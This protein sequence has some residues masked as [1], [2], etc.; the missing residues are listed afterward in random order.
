MSTEPNRSLS[1]VAPF[2]LFSAKD[3]ELFQAG[4]HERLYE[5]FG[6]H[7][8]EYEGVKGTYFAVWAPNAAY[9]SVM[10]DFNN[11]DRYTHTLLPRWDHSGI[12]EG[13]I[14]HVKKGTLYKYF[15]RAR[16]GEELFKGDPFALYWEQRPKTASITWELDYHWKDKKWMEKRQRHNSL[17][18][19]FSVYEVHLGSWR[20]PDPHNHEVF[21][22]YRE[23]AG[24]LAPYAK[25]MGF[26]HVELMPVGEHPFDGSW[27]YQQTGYYAPTSRYGTPQDF[28]AM[29]DAFHQAGIGVILDW[30]PSHFPYDAHGLYRFDG[31]HVYEYADMRKGYHPDWNSYIFNYSRNEVKSFLLSNAIY[32]LDK[33]HLDGLRVDAVASM[34]HLDY[35]RNAGGWVPNE[36]GGR[37]NLEAIAFLKHLNERVYHLFPDTQTIAE[38]STSFYGVSRPT[39]MGGLGFGMKWMMGWMND[40]LAYFKQDPLHRKWHQDEFTFSI[41]YAFSENF[42]LP[43]SHDEVVH[44][45]SPMVY[46]MP[47]D[48][49]QKFANL[50]LMYG[51]MFTH[52]GTKLLFMGDEFGQTEE[53]NYKSELK[54]H[55]LEHPTH[56]GAQR[57]VKELNRLYTTEPA[58]Y[59]KQFDPDGFEW[60]SANDYDNSVLAYMRKGATIADNLIIV[61]NM[62]PVAREEYLLGIPIPGTWN[63]IL[64]SD[65][66]QFYGSGVLN[67]APVSA[68]QQEYNGK[69]YT[70]KL[71]VPPLGIS[72][73]KQG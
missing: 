56:L 15:I 40:T 44:G 10:G 59:L 34:I 39:F 57:F 55:L 60:I 25:E 47:G 32:W 41:M 2:S 70:I 51:Y 1:P 43:L 19:P 64:N 20:R 23:I 11:W 58:L 71:R 14:P 38:E 8:L 52:P 16:S 5:K 28:M 68:V 50:R 31:S 3:I 42:M 35:S 4:T 37:E 12:W 53:W 54:W 66:P 73:L 18:S 65:D 29:V 63:E 33:Y 9:V 36:Q 45:K 7:T 67:T 17:Q 30:V 49:W 48:D 6:A 27:G 21:Y 69:E 62:T 13:F 22:T 46:K 72:V 61:L 24:M 26:T